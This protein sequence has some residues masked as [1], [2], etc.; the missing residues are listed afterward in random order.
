MTTLLISGSRACTPAMCAY[1]R[2]CVQKAADNE[3]DLICLCLVLAIS[4]EHYRLI[5]AI[6]FV[7]AVE[8]LVAIIAG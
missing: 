1:A 4:D 3:W 8:K 2:A 5:G 7:Q 6:Y